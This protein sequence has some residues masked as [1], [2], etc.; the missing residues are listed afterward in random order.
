MTAS[1]LQFVPQFV[2]ADAV[3]N[4]ALAIHDYCRGLGLN[5]FLSCFLADP[6]FHPLL[7]RHTSHSSYEFG[8]IILHYSHGLK[9]SVHFPFDKKQVAIMYH[10][11]TPSRYF[12][13]THPALAAASEMAQRDLESL[14]KSGAAGIA[15]S[16]FTEKELK[17]VGFTRTAVLPYVLNEALMQTAAN[18]RLLNE[19]RQEP[20]TT[21]LVV[22][23][24]SPHKCLED[25]ILIFD[26]YQRYINR[27][28]RLFFVGSFDGTE[29][30]KNR[31]QHLQRRLG[32]E[33]VYYTGM[34]SRSDLHAYYLSADCYL[35]MSE[36]EGF[37]VPLIEAMRFKVPIVA[38]AGG[39][40]EETLRGAGL[41]F[42]EKDWPL[43]AEAAAVVIE[44]R[45]QRGALLTRQNEAVEYYTQAAARSRLKQMLKECGLNIEE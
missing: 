5:S 44:D 4:E 14:A 17:S 33:N 6:D 32:T 36:H 31:L 2:H 26:Y 43:M 16:K 27:R 23:R 40:V 39:A 25:C 37:C 18:M 20:L 8:L 35:S 15:K 13:G 11:V 34:V 45:E 3:S 42:C 22:G 9:R 7:H 41:L 29:A 21:F 10:G 12:R 24:I 30:Y 1:I 38:Y 28:C 19:L